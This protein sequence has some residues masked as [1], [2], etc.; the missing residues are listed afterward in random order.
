MLSLATYCSI[1]DA[2]RRQKPLQHQVLIRHLLVSVVA[3]PLAILFPHATLGLSPKAFFLTLAFGV[4]VEAYVP[5][6]CLY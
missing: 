6:F 1:Y 5:L 3:I 2:V 4:I